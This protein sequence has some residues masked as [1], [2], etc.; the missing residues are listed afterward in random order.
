MIRN[1]AILLATLFTCS[2][3]FSVA[4]TQPEVLKYYPAC[5][6]AVI[7]TTTVHQT[8]SYHEFK[9]RVEQVQKQFERAIERLK[10]QAQDANASGIAIVDKKV[11]GTKHNHASL[12]VEAELIS[13]C[14]GPAEGSGKPVPI[15]ARGERQRQIATGAYSFEFSITIENDRG[16]DIQR[17]E[18]GDNRTVGPEA[19]IYGLPLGA[20]KAQML[21]A[22][23]TPTFELGVAPETQL[24]SYGRDHW[25]TF[26]DDALVQVRSA[27]PLFSRSFINHL[28]F[29]DRFDDR[30]WHVTPT[31]KKGAVITPD[32]TTLVTGASAPD[33]ARVEIFTETYLA[34]AQQ[35]TEVKVT[36]FAL[37]DSP[38]PP[39]FP[40]PD[41]MYSN[42]ALSAL[43][44]KLNAAD[45]ATLTIDDMTSPVYGRMRT[46]RDGQRHL[47][48]VFTL[49]ETMGKALSKI[50][51]NPGF[52]QSR[53][54]EHG[55]WQFGD[56]YF[57]QTEKEALAVAGDNAFYF[58]NMLEYEQDNYT[59][60]IYL[61]PD[62]E[63]YRVYSMEIS[64]Y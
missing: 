57:G 44:A 9:P 52:V 8:I 30:Q 27:S 3:H 60:N 10:E 42:D 26:I 5:D 15:N 4:Q 61:E 39:S 34:N 18:L 14:H 20:S 7:D 58:N 29:D 6:Y 19:G 36:G 1:R 47:L 62:G 55:D 31:L 22:F 41:A 40:L 12:R 49:V 21:D 13:A 24:I 16:K 35:H 50:Y 2:A 46:T 25:L 45:T 59:A 33:A 48:N 32:T 11:K 38:H 54:A 43:A 53:D 63:T 51:I 28:P 23:G 17:P 64:V 56:F 37:T